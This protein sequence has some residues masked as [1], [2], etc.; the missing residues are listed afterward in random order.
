MATIRCLRKLLAGFSVIGLLG[1]A[2]K[3]PVGSA[4]DGGQDVNAGDLAPEDVAIGVDAPARPD[5]PVDSPAPVFASPEVVAERLARMIWN[6]PADAD[7]M[8]MLGAGVSRNSV[9]E[10]AGRMLRDERA[11]A[12]VAAFYR[13]WLLWDGPLPQGS[14]L[15]VSLQA[16]GPA[17]GTYLTLDVDGT[18]GDL[19]TAPYT[20][21]NE[22]L[23]KQYG[24][25]GVSGPEL[26]RVPYPSGQPRLGLLTGVGILSH[27]A[28][29]TSPGWPAKRGWMITDPLL[30]SP[31]A[32]TFLPI[33]PPDRTRS[34]R[35]QMIEMTSSCGGACH[36]I[37]NG[38][39]LAYIGFDNDGRWHPEP[40]AAD[41]ETQG[42][43]P[44]SIMP[45]V[46]TFDGPAELARLLVAREETRR[47]FVRQWMQFALA[48]DAI[49][50][51]KAASDDEGSV[52]A[53]LSA[54]T[55]SGLRLS[56]AIVAVAQTD[57]FLRAG[58]R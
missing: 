41:D 37:L 15:A 2:P 28:S 17:L 36:G 4:V 31:I 13:W 26:R 10:A 29:L 51:P 33:D 54:F 34:I 11:R 43:I 44:A 49:I 38:P 19:L 18:F 25:D 40:G 21:M 1:C 12:G 5:G 55:T 20:F 53:A 3:S 32:R 27:F 30:C 6:A 47:C 22:D 23:A 14:S 24:V 42:W 46:P 7:V 35:Q 58:P 57:A 9:G 56:A 50:T 16:E 39:G 8:A 52:E 45:D 48:R